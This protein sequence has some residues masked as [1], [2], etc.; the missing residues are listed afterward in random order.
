[1][2]DF[3]RF[4]ALASIVFHLF[5]P[6]PRPSFSSS[7][8]S[9][10][11]PKSSSE[12]ASENS[13]SFS[14]SSSSSSSSFSVNPSLNTALLRTRPPFC[15]FF[16]A[17]SSSLSL[18]SSSSSSSSSSIFL[19]KMSSSPVVFAPPPNKEISEFF[20][21]S[22]KPLCVDCNPFTIFTPLIF[23]LPMSLL[24]SSSDLSSPK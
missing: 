10:P 17:S 2:S 3:E 14:S 20:N 19:S 7:S 13:F 4:P 16:S 24:S 18:S 9:S 6:A 15:S 12:S 1:M 22:S 23:P 11:M 21:F 5:A 8:W